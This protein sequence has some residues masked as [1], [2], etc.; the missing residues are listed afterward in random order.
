MEGAFKSPGRINNA[1][2]GHKYLHTV[3]AQELWTCTTCSSFMLRSPVGRSLHLWKKF[4]LLMA[5]LSLEH[6]TSY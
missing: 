3:L 6:L 1:G 2:M 5:M 4:M